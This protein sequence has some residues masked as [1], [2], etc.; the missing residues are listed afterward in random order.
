V[1][2]G[3]LAGLAGGLYFARF[4]QTL[5]F[6]IEPASPASLTLPVVCLAAVAVIAAWSPARRATRVDP[7][8]ALR[9]D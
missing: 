8:E 3:V 5:L 9:A 7:A 4:V 6:E 2:G 1:I